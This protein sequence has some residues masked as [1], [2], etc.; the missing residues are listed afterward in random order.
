V[1]DLLIQHKNDN[2]VGMLQEL[3]RKEDNGYVRMR[4]QRA[5]HEMNASVE[6][7]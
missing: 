4:C 7:F 5:L 6:T 2:L 1:I 3:M